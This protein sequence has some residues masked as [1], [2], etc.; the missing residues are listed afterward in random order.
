MF[1]ALLNA[2][3]FDG[4]WV[5]LSFYISFYKD[6]TCRH[7]CAPMFVS[8][9]QTQGPGWLGLYVGIFFTDEHWIDSRWTTIVG[10]VD[11][12]FLSNLQYLLLA[13]WYTELFLPH[14]IFKVSKCAQNTLLSSAS[15]LAWNRSWWVSNDYRNFLLS[16]KM[17]FT[18]QWK[19]SQ[20]K[21]C[22]Q[23]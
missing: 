23:K 22:C 10:A 1:C 16:L 15:S 3:H 2:A 5:W 7:K 21:H 19:I 18:L 8:Y 14:F 13:F 20:T 11:L 4:Q 12:E 17:C 6:G 9:F